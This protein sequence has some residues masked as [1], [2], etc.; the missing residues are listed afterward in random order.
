MDSRITLN[1]GESFSEILESCFRQKEKVHLLLD[2]EGL[3]CMEGIITAIN[4]DP[5][6]ELIELDGKK[7]IALRS[8]VAV[9][10]MFRPEYG[11]C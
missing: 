3:V 4:R 2:E 6:A 9:N 1:T 5:A 7:K 8:I 11:E 10:G